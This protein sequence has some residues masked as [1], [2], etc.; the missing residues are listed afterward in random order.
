MH[1]NHPRV[2]SSSHYLKMPTAQYL[3]KNGAHWLRFY[4]KLKIKRQR[5]ALADLRGMNYAPSHQPPHV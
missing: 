1:Q 5:Y 4:E 3:I 2:C